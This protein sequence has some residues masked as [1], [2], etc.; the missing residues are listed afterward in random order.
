MTD[1]ELASHCYAFAEIL[2]TKLPGSRSITIIFD[3]DD[4]KIIAKAM[5]ED[6]RDAILALESFLAHQEIKN[7]NTTVH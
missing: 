6:F 4:I 2:E 1:K 5:P 7:E 3:R